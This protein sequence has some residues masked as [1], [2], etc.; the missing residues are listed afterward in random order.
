MTA[1]KTANKPNEECMDEDRVAHFLKEHPEFFVTHVELL[2]KLQIPHPVRGTISL[3]EYQNAHLRECHHRLEKKLAK[4]ICLARENENLST[5]LHELALGL[6]RADSL[7]S[8]LATT[9]DQLRSKFNADTVTLRLIGH[10][11]LLKNTSHALAANAHE[12]SLLDSIFRK[13]QP[14]CGPLPHE[15]LAL[16]FPDSAGQIASTIV[17]PLLDTEPLGVLALGSGDP[18]RFHPSM[19]TLFLGYLGDLVAATISVSLERN[20]SV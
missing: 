10:Y 3:L 19:G 4:L 9:H 18:N 17:I 2:D 7:D 11:N 8:V 12:W 1:P 13:H 6:L 15:L 20:E 16:L 5:N 14:H